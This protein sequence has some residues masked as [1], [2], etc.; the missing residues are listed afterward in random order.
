MQILVTTKSCVMMSAHSSETP[1][2][3]QW[4]HLERGEETVDEF[5]V[6]LVAVFWYHFPHLGKGYIQFNITFYVSLQKQTKFPLVT[7]WSLTQPV[8]N[9]WFAV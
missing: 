6:Y 4:T 7:L 3:Q 1:K 8:Y 2:N 9:N 5:D